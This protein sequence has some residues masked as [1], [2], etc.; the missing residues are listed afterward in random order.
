MMLGLYLYGYLHRVRSSRRLRDECRRNIEAMWLMDGLKPNDKTISNFRTDNKEPLRQVFRA[1]SKACLELGL[2][3]GEVAATDGTKF[4]A[5]NSDKNNYTESKVARELS[6]IEAKANEYMAALEQGDEEEKE[7]KE[8]CAEEIHAALEKLQGRKAKY[9]GLKARIKEGGQ[10]S[11]VD[12]DAKRM[13]GGGAYDVCYN[14]QTVVDS[15][16]CMIV[17]FDAAEY[18]D[19]GNLCRM[20]EKAMEVLEAETLTNLA[21]KGYYDG[22]DLAACEGKG[23]TCLVPKPEGGVKQSKGY[24]YGDFVYDREKDCI[25]CPNQRVLSYTHD[26][27]ERNGR[28]SRAYSNSSA[29]ADCPEKSHCTKGKRRVICRYAYQEVL[30]KIEERMKGSKSLYRRRQE[31]VEHPFGTI[32]Y[33]WGYKQFLCRGKAKILAE[34][35]LVYLA[36][37]MRRAVN[38]FAE[39]GLRLAEAIG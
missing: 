36:Y 9:E 18:F 5:D 30:E 35:A 23:V 32:K 17:D 26:R 13:P 27:K 4:S 12:P 10:V 6:I 21:D 33:V 1:F 29:C 20:S 38:I 16:H 37:N 11:T 39:S 14:I 3:G 8:P 19:K 34:T 24:A 31:I 15:K 2:Y 28:V 22:E 7:G 25:V